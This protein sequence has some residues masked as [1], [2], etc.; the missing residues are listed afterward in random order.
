MGG[1]DR[2][3]GLCTTQILTR[4][5]MEAHN[6]F[7]KS[8]PGPTDPYSG[9]PLTQMKQDGSTEGSD[10][11][12]RQRS[13]SCCSGVEMT[14][15]YGRDGYGALPTD[16]EGQRKEESAISW[17]VPL[18]YLPVFTCTLVLVFIIVMAASNPEK[19]F[20]DG[21]WHLGINDKRPST[22]EKAFAHLNNDSLHIIPLTNK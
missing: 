19:P 4:V 16:E 1:I 15:K 6:V 12:E 18:F 14:R 11:S 7:D 2:E 9:E 3:H 13:H 5:T 21:K 8:D 17:F 10:D 22:A 20:W